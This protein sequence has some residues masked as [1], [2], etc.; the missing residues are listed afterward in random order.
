MTRQ[1]MR[2]IQTTN[3]DVFVA[4]ERP[5]EVAVPMFDL[6]GPAYHST[7]GAWHPPF[8]IQL[9]SWYVVSSTVGTSLLTIAILVGDNLFNTT[10]N[11]LASIDLPANQRLVTGTVQL[12][13]QVYNYP[14][15]AREQWI[16][17]ALSGSSGH[18]D[19]GVQIYGKKV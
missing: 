8:P 4:T 18:S 6:A 15:I 5:E 7:S 17:V 10:G 12:G 19:V 11:F 13:A 9:T 2:L 1:G 16:K 14:V 3:T